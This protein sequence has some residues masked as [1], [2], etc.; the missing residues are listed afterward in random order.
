M[1]AAARTL[2]VRLAPLPGEA[3]DSWLEALARR[4]H[5]PLGEVLRHF[6][7]P[8]RLGRGDHLKGIP[9]DWTILLSEQETMA[10]AYASGLDLQ[11]VTSMTLA[12]Y[13]QRALRIN[14]ERRYVNRWVLWGRG[15][16]SR[17]CPDCLRD[18]DG[19]WQ[20]AWRLGWSYACVLHGLL[21]A[22]CCPDCG[23]IQRQRPRSG[24]VIPPCRDL[25]KPTCGPGRTS[26]KRLRIR[27]DPD[28]YAPAACGASRAHDPEA[29]DE[30]N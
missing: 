29:A 13:D 14:F 16:G 5:T 18:N 11:T 27:S 1:T 26:N 25:R 28:S 2:P 24:R 9:P 19:R 17:F 8:A 22:D 20:L 10:I 30:R 7:F 15:G 21:L 4:L 12:H 23:R 6:G 3:L